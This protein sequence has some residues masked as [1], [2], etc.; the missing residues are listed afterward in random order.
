[1]D[2]LLVVDKPVGP[3]SHEVVARVR[4]ALGTT[5]IG[6]TGTLDPAATGVLPLVLGRATRLARFLSAGDKSYDATIRL[7]VATST[8]DAEGTVVG[9]VHQGPLPTI[10]TIAGALE[11]FRGTFLQTPPAFS[12]KKIGGRRSY[13]IARTHAKAA[14]SGVSADVPPLAAA[15]V[16]ARTI[17]V[18]G[19]ENG[20]VTLRVA[21]SA[22]FYVRSLAH[23]LGVALGIGAH[24]IAL[25]RTRSADATLDD[26]LA[27]EAIERDPDLARRAIVPVSAMLPRLSAVRL[28]RDGVRRAVHGQDVGPGD[29]EKGVSLLFDAGDEP[30]SSPSF[31]R[32]VDASGDLVAIATPARASGLLHPAVV[33]M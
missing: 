2:G 12:A 11:A 31:V 22:G 14:A 32:L 8:Y 26:A 10:D 15:S 1:M 19:I 33:L 16:T 5:R 7:G 3:T 4:R 9:P 23:D 20:A 13:R 17:D 18:I 27:L 30:T 24:L 25:R 6:H 28:T 29:T 21:C